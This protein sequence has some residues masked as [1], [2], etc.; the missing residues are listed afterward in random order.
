MDTNHTDESA[1]PTTETMTQDELAAEMETRFGADAWHWAF[2][3]PSCDDV[4]TPQSFKDAGADPNRVGQEC[5]GRH[6]G[7]LRREQ[8]KGGYQGRGCDWAAYGLFQGPMFVITPE[9][10]Q[11]P[12]FRIAPAPAPEGVTS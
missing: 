7:V 9:G 12:S 3:C 2:I 11:I 5:I 4:A 8:P 1:A 10:K 6:L